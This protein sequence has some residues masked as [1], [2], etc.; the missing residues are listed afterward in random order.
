MKR[1]RKGHAEVKVTSR[2][3]HGQEGW[4]RVTST[5]PKLGAN[6]DQVAPAEGT[7]LVERPRPA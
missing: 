5:W 2:S 3:C 4:A 7:G 6:D 1:S